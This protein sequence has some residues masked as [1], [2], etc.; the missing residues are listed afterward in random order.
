MS[1]S[2]RRNIIG[3]LFEHKQT[4][5]TCTWWGLQ[6]QSVGCFRSLAYLDDDTPAKHRGP[7]TGINEKMKRE[8]FIPFM[9]NFTYKIKGNILPV[10]IKCLWLTS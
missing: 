7:D 5:A 1:C 3:M 9:S 4:E 10:P 6:F 8:K 2:A